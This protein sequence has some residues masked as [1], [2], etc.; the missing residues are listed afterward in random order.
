MLLSRQMLEEWVV[1]SKI[2]SEGVH[3]KRQVKNLHD[4]VKSM[5]GFNDVKI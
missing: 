1:F 5:H 2:T 4:T 3:G